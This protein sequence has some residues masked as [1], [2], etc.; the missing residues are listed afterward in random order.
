VQKTI[1]NDIKL[2]SNFITVR[3]TQ[4]YKKRIII[5]IFYFNMVGVNKQVIKATISTLL[6]SPSVLKNQPK[7]SHLHQ[8]P[9]YDSM[10]TTPFHN[11]PIHIVPNYLLWHY[12][13]YLEHHNMKKFNC[14]VRSF[15][16]AYGLL[17]PAPSLMDKQTKLAKDQQ[18]AKQ[19]Y[20]KKRSEKN[21][22][23]NGKQIANLTCK[24]F[25]S[26]N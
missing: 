22:T 9:L 20:Y 14:R 5:I 25:L 24:I 17:P 10:T 3:V 26:K 2:E 6:I 19:N 7:K 8:C 23:E 4:L 18:R 11:L 1:T 16:R 13:K 21:K 12:N 15:L